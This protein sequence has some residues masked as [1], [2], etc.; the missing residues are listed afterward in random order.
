VI[1][2]L[3]LDVDLAADGFGLQQLAR[4]TTF[5]EMWKVNDKFEVVLDTTDFGHSVGEVELQ[6]TIEIDDDDES[7]VARGKAI[8]ADMDRQI[9]GF[10]KKYSWAFST[11]KPVGKLSAYFARRGE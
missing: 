10:M 4:F 9:E 5:R 3:E 1:R 8:T 6:K 7:S 2:K 11:D